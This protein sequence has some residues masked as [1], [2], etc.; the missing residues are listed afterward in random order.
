M[1]RRLPTKAEVDS[2]LRDWRNWGR[3]GD[4]GGAGAINLITS[5]KRLAAARLARNRRMVSLSRPYPVTPSGENPRPTNHHM[6]SEAHPR[7]G[8]VVM[9]YCGV[10]YH[11]TATTHI[12]AL[13]HVW[14]RN[15]MWDGK[16]PEE[17][18]TYT[19]ARYGTV[20]QWS[21]G[22]L[23]SGVVLDLPKHRG[24]PYVTVEAPVHGWELK[25]IAKSEGIRLEAGDTLMVY[26]GQEAY[27]VEHGGVWGG[28]TH[29]PG[30]HASCLPFLRDNAV[31]ILVRDMMDARPDDYQLPWTVH[32]A[33]FAYGIALVDNALLETLAHACAQEG[34]YEFM[35]TINP[36]KV[37]GGT[38]SP[39][40]P[41][42]VF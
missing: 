37:I 1:E 6:F 11:G 17:V 9:N 36:L 14:D 28:G 20:D 42:A 39:V 4:K 21:D 13:C 3:W 15:G 29:R 35:L 33:I 32:G 18:V 16:K 2:Y 30:L 19:G 26:C 25:D 10:F 27:A 22:I 31:S 12:D 8:G 24:K 41:I 38:G 7:G 34:Q 23:N 40:N 5:Q